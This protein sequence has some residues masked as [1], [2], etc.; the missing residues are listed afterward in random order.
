MRELYEYVPFVHITQMESSYDI[1]A[2]WI[3][4]WL[5]RWVDRQTA[6]WLDR[7]ID[8]LMDV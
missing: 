3:V 8:V 7:Q 2:G 5:D 1:A 4:G 6:R